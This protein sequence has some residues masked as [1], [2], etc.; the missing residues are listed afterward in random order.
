MTLKEINEFL[1]QNKIS[2]NNMTKALKI[3]HPIFR[4]EYQQ[5]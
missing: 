5:E 1:S 3:Q 4:E 2:S